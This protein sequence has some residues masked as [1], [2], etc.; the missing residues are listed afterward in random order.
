MAGLCGWALCPGLV[1]L[2]L[3][4]AARPPPA[5][6]T[7]RQKP[8]HWFLLLVLLSVFLYVS[9]LF[10]PFATGFKKSCLQ[11]SQLFQ[12]LSAVLDLDIDGKCMMKWE[13]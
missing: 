4:L 6:R 12:L 5:S 10:W 9:S 1:L 3:V 13:L 2:V 8:K 7:Y 11:L